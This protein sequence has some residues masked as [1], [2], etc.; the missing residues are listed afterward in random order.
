MQHNKLYPWGYGWTRRYL[1]SDAPTID[2][3][4]IYTVLL[5]LVLP[6]TG[7]DR[8]GIL[9]LN[10]CFTLFLPVVGDRSC[11]SWLSSHVFY[12]RKF[13]RRAWTKHIKSGINLVREAVNFNNDKNWLGSILPECMS[14]FFFLYMYPWLRE[15]PCRRYFLLMGKYSIE[16][17]N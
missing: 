10:C 9:C 16:W 4:D 2:H 12:H 14:E 8:Y 15:V 5:F 6:N 3:F 7:I 17:Y 1:Y 11:E 13:T